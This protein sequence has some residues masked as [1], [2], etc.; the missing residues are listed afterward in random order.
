MV[1]T[2]RALQPN[3]II[4]LQGIMHVTASR[5]MT[6]PIFTNANIVD[7]NKA[8]AT[9]A[10]GRDIFYIDM[11]PIVCDENGDVL[12]EHSADDVHLR[13]RAYPLWA[14]FLRNN[15]IIR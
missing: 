13:A 12:E 3:A 2:I 4:F 15:G 1:E 10:N 7:K 5:S 11:N 14:D 6:D 9:L 8:I